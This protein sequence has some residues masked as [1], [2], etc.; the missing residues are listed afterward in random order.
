MWDVRRQDLRPY[1][2]QA[3]EERRRR[4]AIEQDQIKRWR[5]RSL[6]L[7]ASLVAMIVVV[8]VYV[9]TPA[10]WKKKARDKARELVRER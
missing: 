5:R 4:Y 2:R 10:N 3:W 9:V 7:V 6:L 8:W 1:S